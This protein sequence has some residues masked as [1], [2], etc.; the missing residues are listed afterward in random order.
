MP[1][2]EVHDSRM[3]QDVIGPDTRS[4]IQNFVGGGSPPYGGGSAGQGNK[5]R[6]KG[7]YIPFEQV[8]RI[9]F[10]V[11]AASAV[12]KPTWRRG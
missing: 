8:C 7:S 3:R 12:D 10:R 9:M 4:A 6:I 1:V 11:K 5:G 2:D